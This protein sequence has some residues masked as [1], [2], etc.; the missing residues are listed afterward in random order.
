MSMSSLL[1]LGLL[2][3]PV[4]AAIV[5]AMLGPR[6]LDAIR[7]TSLAATL[8]SLLFAVVLALQFA[9]VR[10]DSTQPAATTFQPEFV[11]GADPA[12]P[13]GTTWDLLTFPVSAA[14]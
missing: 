12:K 4:V 8:V 5:V 3:V 6:R 14:A 9:L 1:L 2:G 11:P 7:Q 10:A 13:H